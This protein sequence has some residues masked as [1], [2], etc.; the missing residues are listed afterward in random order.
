MKKK[1]GKI[2]RNDIHP[3]QRKWPELQF[4]ACSYADSTWQHKLQ[5]YFPF[6]VKFMMVVVLLTC[7]KF[8]DSLWHL[9]QWKNPPVLS[10]FKPPL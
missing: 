9:G 3:K 10:D 2:M 6:R 7:N 5:Y 1:N 8:Q 4:F